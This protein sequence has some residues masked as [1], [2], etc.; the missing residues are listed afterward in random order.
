LILRQYLNS[1]KI[2]QQE[3]VYE[4]IY[5]DRTKSEINYNTNTTQPQTSKYKGEYQNFVHNTNNSNPST[6]PI[7]CEPHPKLSSE[8][9]Q[10]L[11]IARAQNPL[12]FQQRINNAPNPPVKRPASE[13]ESDSREVEAPS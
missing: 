1:K 2:A 9:T 5:N 8:L 13:S 7:P 4:T 3:G 6:T 11:N 10:K 12:N